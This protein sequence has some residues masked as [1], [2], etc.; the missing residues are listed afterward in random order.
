MRRLSTVEEF[1]EFRQRILGEKKQQDERPTLVVCAGT[2]GPGQRFERHHPGHQAIHPRAGSAG[3]GR[4]ADH[5]LPGLLRDG[6]LHPRGAR[7]ATSTPSSTMDDVPRVIEAAVG[8][9]VDESLIYRDPHD[10]RR[11]AQPGRH[12]VLQEA[13]AHHPGQQREARSDPDPQL[14]RAGRLRGRREG[15]RTRSI[16]TGSSRR[17]RTPAC[18]AA[19][20]PASPPAG[21]GS[22]PARPATAAGRSTS[23]AT[24]TRAIPAPT[25]TAACSRA[26]P[27]PSSRA[28]SSAGIAIGATEG[29]I[30]V[31]SEYPLAIKH[32]VIAL[33]QARDLGL[34]GKNIL[35]TGFDFDIEIVRGAGAF[36]CGEETALIRSI[37]GKMGEPRQRPPYPDREGASTASPT[38]INNVETWANIPVIIDRGAEAYAKVGVPGN[39]GHQDLLAWSGRSRTPAWSRCRWASR[40]R[41][42]VYDIG[43]GPLGRARRS[44]RC[45]P[46][47]PPAAASPPACSTCPSTTTACAEAG[48]I[49][50]SGGMI[51]MDENTCMVDVAKYFMSFLKDESCGKCFTCRKGTQRMYEILDDITEGRATLEHLDLL[52]ELA[53]VVKDTTHVRP[54][55]VGRQPGAQHAALLPRRVRARTSSTS[56][57]TPSSARS[58]SARPA[59]PPARSAPRRGATS[60]TSRRGE[61]EEAYRAIR[62]ANPVP[63]GLR[64]GL[65]PPVR[66]AAAGPA[67]TGGEPVAIRALKRFVTDRDRSLDLQAGPT[68]RRPTANRRGWPSS[69]P[70]P[71]AS[72]RPTTSRCRAT[73]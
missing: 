6:A 13:D 15:A 65:R 25:W 1:S 20:A 4:P 51:V 40:S 14:H 61:Y 52:E 33:R 18:A 54:R 3:E 24:P 44:R 32:A 43:G 64:P 17:S 47:D 57:A 16:R 69:A 2:C 39:T 41:E 66:D 42:I 8:G 68:R 50:G 72:P 27:T 5:R 31:R 67:R 48:S 58:W 35:G 53:H 19:A 34:L 71:P 60:P 45:R 21:S 10:D 46:A 29:F 23:S 73:R 22:W 30:Y 38:C 56:A 70:G 63:L 9:F 49:M 37:E 11:Y 59:R 36:V 7:A 26:T 62:E 12:P 28:C 55:P